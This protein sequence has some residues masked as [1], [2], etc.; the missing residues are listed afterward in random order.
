MK[1]F[2]KEM[3][4]M[5]GDINEIF[6]AKILLLTIKQKESIKKYTIFFRQ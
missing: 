5:F 1:K 6:M 4:V 2:A 3:K